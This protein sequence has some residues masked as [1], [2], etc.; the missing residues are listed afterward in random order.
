M[1][2]SPQTTITRSSSSARADSRQHAGV[3]TGRL[4]RM[5]FQIL[6]I[7]PAELDGIRAA[8]RDVAGNGYRPTV[9]RAGGSPLR[10]CLR[11]TRPGEQVALIAYRPA[12][13]AGAY[14]ET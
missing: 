12:G 1:S 10:C 6:A 4:D 13:T 3:S 5:S 14:A 11:L 8:G 9:D 2:A 7:P